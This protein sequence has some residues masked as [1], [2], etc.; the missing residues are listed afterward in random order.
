MY[1][2]YLFIENYYDIHG[3]CSLIKVDL[4]NSQNTTLIPVF[5]TSDAKMSG[6]TGNDLGRQNTMDRMAP[7]ARVHKIEVY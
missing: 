5:P 3:Q 7:H 2:Q 4:N 1:T 6:R